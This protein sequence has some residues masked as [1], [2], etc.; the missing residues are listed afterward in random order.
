MYF[1]HTDWKQYV[2]SGEVTEEI[3]DISHGVRIQTG[4]GL[5]AQEIH[6]R[7]KRV[8]ASAPSR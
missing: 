5:K 8:C 7:K 6:P 1:R 4:H 3:G 2:L